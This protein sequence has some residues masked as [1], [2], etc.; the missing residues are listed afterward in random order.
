MRKTEEIIE[1]L[2]GDL[3]PVAAFA[4]ERRLALAALPA[5]GFS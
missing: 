2:A 4:L 1:K 5:L 3:K